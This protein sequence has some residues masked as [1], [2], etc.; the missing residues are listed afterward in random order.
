MA[1]KKRKR[2]IIRTLIMN[3][4]TKTKAEFFTSLYYHS[5]I[6]PWTAL[7]DWFEYQAVYY[8]NQWYE[9]N[10]EAYLKK[11]GKFRKDASYIVIRCRVPFMDRTAVYGAWIP[12]D[13]VIKVFNQYEFNQLRII[14][15]P[16]LINQSYPA[17]RRR[18]QNKSRN[19]L[20]SMFYMVN[21]CLT[22]FTDK[23]I[24]IIQSV[25]YQIKTNK[26][27]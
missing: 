2:K 14:L 12:H 27:K 21:S 16:K 10:L 17:I 7:V 1:T 13:K 22:Q 26:L 18:L 20:F 25:K 8:W 23:E 5:L 6:V 11:Y 19:V 24:K 9:E 3:T 4:W 15:G